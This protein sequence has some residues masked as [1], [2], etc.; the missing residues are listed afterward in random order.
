MGQFLSRDPK[1]AEGI[2][3]VPHGTGGF[4]CSENTAN[5]NPCRGIW[6]TYGE[7][8]TRVD[9][10]QKAFCVTQDPALQVAAFH[11]H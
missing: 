10:L 11:N 7:G 9:C 3:G 6:E 2:I 5:R 1:M 4:R 8:A